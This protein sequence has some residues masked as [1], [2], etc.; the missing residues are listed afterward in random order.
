MCPPA[1]GLLVFPL[2]AQGSLFACLLGRNCQ[3]IR[4]CK[5]PDAVAGAANQTMMDKVNL[6]TITL[7]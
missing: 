2:N 5:L 3:N 7:S 4:F 1:E 6:E